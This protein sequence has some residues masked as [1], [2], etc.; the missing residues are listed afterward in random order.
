MERILATVILPDGHPLYICQQMHEYTDA[1][2]SCV[3]Y[4]EGLK[5][6]RVAGGVITAP[7][8]H[9]LLKAAGR[10]DVIELFHVPAS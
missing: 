8:A 7:E 9:A 3:S 4:Y 1:A 5:V 6:A 10:E 2:T